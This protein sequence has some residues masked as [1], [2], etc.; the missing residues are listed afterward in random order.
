MGRKTF[1]VEKFRNDTNAILASKETA[2]MYETTI[3]QIAYCECKCTT[4][5]RVLHDTGNYEGFMF[6]N[7]NDIE[8]NTLGYF[9]RKYF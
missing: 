9:K 7:N 4:L 6:I 1:S 8:I 3:A 2:T 5:E